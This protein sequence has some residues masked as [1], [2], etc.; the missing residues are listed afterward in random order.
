MTREQ[1]H[2]LDASGSWSSPSRAWC[3]PS[4]TSGTASVYLLIVSFLTARAV[5]HIVRARE[6]TP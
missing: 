1:W 3:S 2:E 5:K 4:S 6:A